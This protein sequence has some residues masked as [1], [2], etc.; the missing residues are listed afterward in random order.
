M[1]SFVFYLDLIIRDIIRTSSLANFSNYLSVQFSLILHSFIFS[2]NS[3]SSTVSLDGFQLA[4]EDN[5]VLSRVS[6]EQWGGGSKARCDH[7]H[8]KL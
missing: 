1:N 4:S 2:P 5:T 3:L 7:G 6:G 8:N